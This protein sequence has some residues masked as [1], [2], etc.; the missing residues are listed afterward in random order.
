[1]MSIGLEGRLGFLR[2]L[3]LSEVQ[4]IIL[5]FKSPRMRML[6]HLL[7][8]TGLRISKASSLKVDYMYFENRV[9]GSISTTFHSVSS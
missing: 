2:R 1:M 3:R 9:L 4:R 5:A 7:A 6:L 8:A